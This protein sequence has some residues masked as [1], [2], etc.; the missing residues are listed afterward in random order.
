MRQGW[1]AN[2]KTTNVNVFRIQ[3]FSVCAGCQYFCS[4]VLS[5]CFPWCI[6]QEIWKKTEASFNSI[7]ND[8][9]GFR[10]GLCKHKLQLVLCKSEGDKEKKNTKIFFLKELFFI[11]TE[12][13]N[14]FWTT[15][16]V[17]LCLWVLNWP[18][19]RNLFTS[20]STTL[21][22]LDFFFLRPGNK[23]WAREQTVPLLLCQ[24]C[25]LFSF[26]VE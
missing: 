12:N 7:K 13:T 26:V 24:E 8:N 11:Q 1:A 21:Y 25:N 4:N 5:I 23:I 6:V 14:I 16:F 18:N 9:L 2:W 15:S 10:L 17:S 22:F 3:H 20:S 19:Y